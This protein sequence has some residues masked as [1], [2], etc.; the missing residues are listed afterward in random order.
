[1]YLI[2][3]NDWTQ[4]EGYNNALLDETT[5]QW[6]DELNKIYQKQMNNVWCQP[7]PDIDSNLNYDFIPNDLM[8]FNVDNNHT[9]NNP[10]AQQMV[11]S[12]QNAQPSTLTVNDFMIS[13]QQQQQV[14][15]LYYNPQQAFSQHIPLAH[16]SALQ[17]PGP[18]VYKP[19]NSKNCKIEPPI[20]S[21]SLI[22]HPEM[23]K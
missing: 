11:G 5:A 19:V 7:T 1:M 15:P 3:S 21:S 8:G 2:R 16:T 9:T 23:S 22:H 10:N 6:D 20:D 12:F 14:P 17:Y 18:P 13:Q 4:D